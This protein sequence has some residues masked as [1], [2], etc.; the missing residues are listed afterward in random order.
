[1]LDGLRDI[2]ARVPKRT[3]RRHPLRP[4][5]DDRKLGNVFSVY[6]ALFLDFRSSPGAL[7]FSANTSLTPPKAG[8][9]E[10]TFRCSLLPADQTSF[11]C[12]NRFA[13]T[14]SAASSQGA[15]RDGDAGRAEAGRRLGFGG[16]SYP[17]IGTL[18]CAGG[19]HAGDWFRAD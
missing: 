2:G 4:G 13:S 5:F 17:A 7:T 6:G 18:R 8:V 19:R 1:M 3:C 9:F 12:W 14:A 10:A 16:V 11:A 15:P